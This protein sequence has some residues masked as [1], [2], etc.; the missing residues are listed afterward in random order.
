MT[1]FESRTS[2]QP[3]EKVFLERWS[4]RAMTGEAMPP[5]A[6][7][8][9]FEAA[10]WAPSSYNSQPWRFLYAHNGTPQFAKILNLLVPGN[11]PWA[12][13]A[14]VL[15]VAISKLMMMARGNEVASHSHAFDTGAAW[16]NLALQ[17]L[18]MGWHT[19]GMTGIDYP[20]ATTELKVPDGYRVE[21]AIAIGKIADKSKLPEGY[22]A[23]EAPSGRNP[24]SSFAFDTDFPA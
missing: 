5:A 6:L 4:P 11:Q 24:V 12:K 15:I 14:S 13:D 16:E 7:A 3:I 17:A 22:Q 23:M 18:H 21:A 20:R 8:A 19:H 9:M 10:R 1:T 2:D